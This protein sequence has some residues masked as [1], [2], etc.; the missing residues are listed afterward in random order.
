VKIA[1]IQ[2]K[3][4]SDDL[5]PE[6]QR[7]EKAVRNYFTHFPDD[8]QARMALFE[9]AKRS[10]ILKNYETSR[11]KYEKIL[12]APPLS[13]K[14]DDIK[15]KNKVFLSL[16]QLYL[17]MGN[18]SLYEAF[19]LESSAL[20]K[21]LSK[22]V[23]EEVFRTNYNLAIKQVKLLQKEGKIK[24]AAQFLALWAKNYSLNPYSPDAL[25]QS[26]EEF[27]SLQE[28]NA[29]LQWTD[30]F[31]KKY[32]KNK[33]AQEALF[34]KAKALD[35]LLQFSKA[36]RLYEKFSS[37][38][39]EHLND[40]KRIFALTRA[41]EIY[42]SF[43][44][45]EDALRVFVELSQIKNQ[46]KIEIEFGKKLFYLEDYE[47]SKLFFKKYLSSKLKDS[48]D[49]KEA[50]IFY[51]ASCFY[52]EKNRPGLQKEFNKE[53]IYLTNIKYQK[54]YRDKIISFMELFLKLNYDNFIIEKDHILEK[55]SL[56]KI[57][58]LEIQRELI[59]KIFKNLKKGGYEK[60][61]LYS[62]GKLFSKLSDFLSKKYSKYFYSKEK[63]DD[64]LKKSSSL[65]DESKKMLYELI[66]YTN[67][68]LEEK[69]IVSSM[70][71]EYTKRNFNITPK[72]TSLYKYYLFSKENFIENYKKIT[73][74][75]SLF[76]EKK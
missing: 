25:I 60:N 38:K 8:P 28:W 42:E 1:R 32:S 2:S 35:M 65:K 75:V 31:E 36:S 69:S 48:K 22:Q 11:Q 49:F 72:E 37:Q 54:K 15:E 10:E 30:F 24:N 45:K 17:K 34:W 39:K 70:L 29:V 51:L 21:N 55:K 6:F 3:D 74:N 26:I 12:S 18:N 66:N 47:K 73:K 20:E 67:D 62:T 64:F 23:M 16:A 76:E 27:G 63:N 41:F 40:K 5:T 52:N 9:S 7:Y 13:L 46:K 71:Y 58:D 14:E 57:K 68:S 53:I 61:F 4:C 59:N 50:K 33:K 43:S 19:D 44:K 56:E